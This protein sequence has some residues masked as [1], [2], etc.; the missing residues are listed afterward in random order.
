MK[1]KITAIGSALLSLLSFAAIGCASTLPHAAAEPLKTSSAKPNFVFILSDDQAPDT[2]AAWGN[3][4]IITPNLDRLSNAGTNFMNAYNAGSWSRAVCIP[5]R[6]MINSG[7]QVWQS[8]A[9]NSPEGLEEL[10]FWSHVMRDAGYATYMT[11]KW[12]LSIPVDEA[13]EFVS[14]A[15]PGM[16]NVV[17]RSHPDAY[18]RPIAGAEDTWDPSDPS[19]G[20]FWEGGKHWS[21]VVA[22]DAEIFIEQAAADERPFFMYLA[23]NAPHDPRQAPR[24]YIDKYPLQSMELPEN[25]LP[26]YPYAEAIGAPHALR[27]E[28]LAP[29]PRTEHAVKVHRQE[30]YAITTHMDTQIGRILDALEAS[31]Q[32]ENTYIIFTSDQLTG[33]RFSAAS[34]AVG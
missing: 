27:D 30:L 21:E 1:A 32:A 24:E 18:N 9:I 14:N 10:P 31:G 5:S 15:R 19:R 17:P 12:H 34:A 22:D 33:I 8:Q 25:F 16:P 11:G 7:L 6:V 20:G 29:M 28:F 2:V 3:P 4:H 26:E 13:Y 23:F